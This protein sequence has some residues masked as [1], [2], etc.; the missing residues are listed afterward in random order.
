MV[1]LT[2]HLLRTKNYV[3]CSPYPQHLISPQSA[4]EQIFHLTNESKLRPRVAMLWLRLCSYLVAE[5]EFKL[6]VSGSKVKIFLPLQ[7]ASLN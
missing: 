7:M 1:I 6:R 3:R 5:Q 4:V 2:E